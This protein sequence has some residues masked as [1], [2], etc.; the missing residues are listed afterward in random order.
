MTGAALRLGRLVVR[1]SCLRPKPPGAMR[2]D[3]RR[4]PE[5]ARTHIRAPRNGILLQ[6]LATR[7]G[8]KAGPLRLAENRKHEDHWPLGDGTTVQGSQ[9]TKQA[10]TRP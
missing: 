4:A 10:A 9:D 2:R 6:S 7:D 3:R 5:A 8:A 1:V